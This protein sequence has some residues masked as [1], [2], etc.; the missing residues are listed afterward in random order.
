MDSAQKIANCIQLSACDLDIQA[1]GEQ[2]AKSIIGLGLAE[3]MNIL[4][5]EQSANTIDKLVARYKYHFVTG[6]DT[7]QGLFDGVEQGLQRLSD[8]GALLA[9][10]T[11]KSRA[12]LNRV[13]ETLSLK[14]YFVA[15]R[16]ADETRSKPHP[17]M[18]HELLDYT[19]IDP[20]KTLM[21]GDTSYDM[22]MADNAGVAGLGVSY[23]VHSTESLRQAKAIDVLH[24]FGSVVDWLF[25]QRLQ[26]AYS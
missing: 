17:Q 8:S 5:P 14:Q 4:F 15:T 10:A 21:I 24:S 12:G 3:A 6:D 7:P 18:L 20:I 16:C 23:G 2:A 22:E 11:G 9:I 25:E 1:P 19:S 26:T 13:F